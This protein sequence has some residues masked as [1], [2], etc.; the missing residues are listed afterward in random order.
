MPR[1][2]YCCHCQQGHAVPE[3]GNQRMLKSLMLRLMLLHFSFD[4]FLAVL[5]MAPRTLAYA[6]A[7]LV[8]LRTTGLALPEI[9][10]TTLS[11]SLTLYLLQMLINLFSSLRTSFINCRGAGIGTPEAIKLVWSCHREVVHDHGPI[12]EDWA[13]PEP[14]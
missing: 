3:Q 9:P 2:P 1:A 14:N 7:Q 6:L 11:C 4:R 5:S 13:M 10:G 12:S 8:H